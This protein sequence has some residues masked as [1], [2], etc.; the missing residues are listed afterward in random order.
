M[1][2]G[3][4]VSGFKSL[5]WVMVLVLVMAACSKVGPD[6]VKPT[7]QAPDAWRGA[8]ASGLNAG[9]PEPQTL[10]AW[11]SR[12]NDPQLSSLVERAAAH[13]LDLKQAEARLRE[14]HARRGLARAA[15]LPTVDAS[16]QASRSLASKTLGNGKTGNLFTTGFDAK[17]ELDLWGGTR[18]AVE[19]ADATLESRAED[20][21]DV[22]VSLLAEVALN[23]LEV[24]TY[25]TR[26]Q[27]TEAGLEAQEQ[28]LQLAVWRYQA[29]LADELAVQQARTN[30]E[31]TRASIPSLRTGLEEAANRL[32]VLLGEQPGAVHEEIMT[33]QPIPAAPADIAVGVPADILR[34][35]PDIRRAERNLAAQTA[36]I[37][38][39]K[40]E[41]YPKFT[42]DGSIGVEALSLGK[43]FT[44][45]S[46]TASESAL[47]S[48]RIFDA[49]SVRNNIKAQSALQEQYLLAYEAAVLGA[50]EEVENALAAYAGEE[51]R[52]QALTAATEAAQ[53]AADLAR[54]K[55]QAGLSDF[56][57][58][59]D[60]ERSLLTVQDQLAQSV[61]AASSDVV[62][63][64]KAL[65]GGW[66]AV[67]AQ[68]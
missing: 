32:A 16:G 54:N 18:R 47:L 51:K 25:Q 38:V 65:G 30:L 56:I 61:G 26:L 17:W 40:A 13:N 60:A 64:Y 42:L 45:N 67:G 68:N 19:A 35:R 21:R 6:Y 63:L 24:R 55:Y 23:Y 49:G 48:W 62:R 20:Q 37:G 34:Q 52:R 58:V 28:T 50:L 5:W 53:I 33:P 46:H 10:A 66:T 43:L 31:S 57:D 41:L 14:A 39:A 4:H 8:T 22:L 15:L 36:E 2:R 59:L 1:K 29:G 27:V 44:A 11:W 12:F 9:K 7:T 3:H